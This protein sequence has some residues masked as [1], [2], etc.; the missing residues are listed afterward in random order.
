MN[1]AH[2]ME[3]EG[4]IPPQVV[5]V[6][7][8]R[9]EMLKA[10]HIKVNSN[11]FAIDPNLDFD[12]STILCEDRVYTSDQT[13]DPTQP[14]TF[15]IQPQFNVFRSL[16]ESRFV[17]LLNAV[18]GTT[19][20]TT[21]GAFM[22]LI[23]K[24][25]WS[26]LF[27]NNFV[28]NINNVACNDQHSRTAQY[29]HF[30]KTVLTEG[31]LKTSYVVNPV[32]NTLVGGGVNIL[33]GNMYGGASD[34]LRTLSEGIINT[35]FWAGLDEQTNYTNNVLSCIAGS[36]ATFL[37]NNLITSSAF[38]ILMNTAAAPGILPT[39]PTPIKVSI[40]LTYRPRDGIW[41][42]PKLLP[43]GVNLNYVFNLSSLGSWCNGYV[44]R[45][46]V[47]NPFGIFFYGINPDTLPV[48]YTYTI[49]RAQYFERQYVST[50]T[51]LKS[52][53][54]L[55][56]RQPL[57]FSCLTSNTLL[58]PVTA[59]QT[60]VQLTNVFSGRLP[61]IV[62]VAL[63]NQSPNTVTYAAVGNALGAQTPTT[64]N[65]SQLLTYSPL[66][67]RDRSYSTAAPPVRLSADCINSVVLTVNGRVYPH[68][69]TSNMQ[70]LSNQDLS[71]WYE[72]YR[73][74]SLICKGNG[75]QEVD[76]LNL[77]Y[78][79]DN[80]LLSFGEFK[81]NLTLCCFNIRRN[82]TVIKNSGDKEV[83]G[84]DMLVNINGTNHPNAQ[85]MVVGINTDSLMTITD[86]GSTTSFVF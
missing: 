55:I 28:I 16:S 59:T 61:N 69:W 57:Y 6:E 44:D 22:I 19:P 68:L 53:Q 71:Q 42:Q 76:N 2:E 8:G 64:G 83:G 34:D 50:Q 74:C 60:S 33:F 81:A 82:G 62:V 23:P 38:P 31:N 39:T 65:V 17:F 29:A 12:A 7:Q 54:S 18:L 30:V 51:L 52:Y 9:Q 3:G 80:P 32:T 35:D 56:M 21:P 25:Y 37:G 1:K 15:T 48:P 77:S 26:A 45:T 46:Q 84:I 14:L 10:S 63:L 70:S 5:A 47:Y 75:R 24:P 41:Q 58:F 72:Q 73:Q 13:P 36:G 20:V 40:E 4:L 85:L 67:G 66:P 49:V 11:Y 78:K 27:V 43:P 86:G 79:M